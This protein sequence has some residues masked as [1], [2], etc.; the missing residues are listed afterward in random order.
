MAAKDRT[1]PGRIAQIRQAYAMTS[2]VDPKVGLISGGVFAGVFV[3]I[4]L[5]GLLVGHPVYLGIIG[6][7]L[8]VLAATVV[9]S[10]RAERAA[11]AQVEG[12]PGAA[13]A[14]LNSLRGKWTVTPAV[15]VT[16]NQDVIHRVVGR[17]GI[18]LVGEG[19]PGRTAQL[20]AQEK[21]KLARV[22]PD[23]PVY[24]VLAGTGEGEVPLRK[25]QRHFM[26]LPRNLNNAEVQETNRRLR[27][28]GTMTLPIPKG[29]MPRNARM[30]RGPRG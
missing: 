28:L 8:A 24:E 2:K 5:I 25:L 13:A 9:F 15:A 14:V 3:V 29:P 10:R 20:I 16:R 11:Y 18:V 12:Q 19:S 22:C 6:L 21:K 30:P 23:A 26:K 17:P 7:F 4:L 1:K 27:A